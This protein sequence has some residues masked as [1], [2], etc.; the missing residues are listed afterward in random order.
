MSD[1]LGEIVPNREI[2]EG[3]AGRHRFRGR[4]DS[5]GARLLESAPE[6]AS[7]D[8]RS[9]APPLR[10]LEGGVEKDDLRRV[11]AVTRLERSCFLVS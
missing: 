4:P 9:L 11:S 10:N 5:V 8:E 6:L 2:R 3:R 7:S 1:P